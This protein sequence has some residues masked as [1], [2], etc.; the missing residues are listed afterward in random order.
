MTNEDQLLI[1]IF[2]MFAVTYP[3]RLIP[4]VLFNRIDVPP[5]FKTW[6]SYVPVSIF[7]ALLTQI[8]AGNSKGSFDLYKELPLLISCIGTILITAKTRSIAWG[9]GLGFILFIILTYFFT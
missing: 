5:I 8:I 1:V 7:A 2:G 6:L 9:M 4:L 3:V